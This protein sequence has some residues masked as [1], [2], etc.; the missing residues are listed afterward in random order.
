MCTSNTS[1]S[2]SVGCTANAR[3]L[4]PPPLLAVSLLF[5]I[6]QPIWRWIKYAVDT[7]SFDDLILCSKLHE[8][9]VLRHNMMTK[10]N[11]PCSEG[12][13]YSSNNMATVV[14][15]DSAVVIATGYGLDGLEI[16]SQWR[17]DF[18]HPSS[19]AL[20]L[21]QPPIQWVPGLFRG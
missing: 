7:M 21:T 11:F 19:P 15:W 3:C 16:E 1:P 5:T 2:L 6:M 4:L 18:P 20:G 14:G 12:T 9:K 10:L 17:R 13:V 8:A